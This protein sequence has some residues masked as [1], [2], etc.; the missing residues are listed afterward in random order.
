M[1]LVATGASVTVGLIVTGGL[2]SDAPPIIKW[3]IGLTVA[4]AE[5]ELERRGYE[6]SWR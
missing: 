5:A 3:M 2:V 1:M 6:V 4:D